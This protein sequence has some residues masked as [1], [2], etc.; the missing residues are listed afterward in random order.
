M[1]ICWGMNGRGGSC[2]GYH[3]SVDVCL[4]RLERVSSLTHSNDVAEWEK[5]EE[6]DEPQAKRK[7]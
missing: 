1:V 7:K 4:G 6:S 3:R 5:E 2:P